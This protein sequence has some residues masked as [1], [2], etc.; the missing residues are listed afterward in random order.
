M[1]VYHTSTP[2]HTRRTSHRLQGPLPLRTYLVLKYLRS[3]L[4][5]GRPASISNAV[6]AEAVGYG[7]EGEVSQI[8]RWLSGEL[9]LSGRWAHRYL[10]APQQLRYIE[11]ERRPD[12]G[13]TTTLLATPAPLVLTDHDPLD[14]PQGAHTGAESAIFSHD[15]PLQLSFFASE[16]E[17]NEIQRDHAIESTKFTKEEE[18]SAHTREMTNEARPPEPPQPAARPLY[19][20]LM[21]EPSMSHSLARRIAAAPLGTLADF[22]HDLA[23]AASLPSVASPLYFTVARWRDGQR[24]ILQERHHVQA[25]TCAPSASPKHAHRRRGE[26]P[27]ARG[28]A[29][30]SGTAHRKPV[31]YDEFLAQ[32]KAANPDM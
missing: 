4:T 16:S 10:E 11:R 8:M 9:P 30:S 13:Y 12:G 7:S 21:N 5:P 29:A 3:V 2:H 23:L 19:H 18:E 27:G 1:Q 32:I 22:E 15:P 17:E 31:D 14:D 26:R 25:Q 20:R 6:L 28:G 24:V